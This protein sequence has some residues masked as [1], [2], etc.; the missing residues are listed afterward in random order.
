MRPAPAPQPLVLSPNL[1]DGARRAP[2][3]I[4]SENGSAHAIAERETESVAERQMRMGIT[5]SLRMAAFLQVQ[6]GARR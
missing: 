5:L 6:A 3:T 2:S 1:Y 4:S